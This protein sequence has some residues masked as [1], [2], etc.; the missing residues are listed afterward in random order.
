LEK[1]SAENFYVLEHWSRIFDA[2]SSKPV[3]ERDTFKSSSSSSTTTNAQGKNKKP[4][5]CSLMFESDYMRIFSCFLLVQIRFSFFFFV[6]KMREKRVLLLLF[7]F[8]IDC[9]K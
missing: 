2:V 7:F 1:I 5:S 6:I 3:D 9:P 8:Y 4:I